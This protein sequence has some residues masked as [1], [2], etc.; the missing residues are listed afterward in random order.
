[1]QEK[2]AIEKYNLILQVPEKT[3][4]IWT[5]CIQNITAKEKTL[6]Q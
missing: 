6:N 1:M 2:A 3:W 4:K 5:F